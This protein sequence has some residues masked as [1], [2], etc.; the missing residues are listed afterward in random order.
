MATAAALS[1]ETSN[2]ME[3]EFDP[4]SPFAETIKNLKRERDEV[5]H[6]T[7]PVFAFLFCFSVFLASVFPAPPLKQKKYKLTLSRP[8]KQYSPSAG[9][10]TT[11]VE[12]LSEYDIQRK[13]R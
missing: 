12:R 11:L 13:K 3:M 7:Y 10:D 1:E 6:G 5:Q 8:P 4:D 9:S 2:A